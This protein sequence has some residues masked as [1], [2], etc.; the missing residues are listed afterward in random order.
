MESKEIEEIREKAMVP[1]ETMM[2]IT[3]SI[4]R[5]PVEDKTISVSAMYDRAIIAEMSVKRRF[6]VN[7]AQYEE[8]MRQHILREQEIINEMNF[9]LK[10]QQF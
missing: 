1:D 6:D 3:F 7:I 5:Y 4:G 9:A 8:T 2:P 10:S